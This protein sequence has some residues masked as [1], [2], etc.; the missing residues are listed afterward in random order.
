MPDAATVRTSAAEAR[1]DLA[2]RG[3]DGLRRRQVR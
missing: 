1:A 3:A 2:E